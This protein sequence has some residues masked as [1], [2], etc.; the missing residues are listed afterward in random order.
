[1]TS[2][3]RTAYPRFK[4]LITAH[5]LQ[6]L[7]EDA[8]P[9]ATADGAGYATHVL[10]AA[11]HIDLVE[12]LLA[13]GRSPHAIRRAQA[14]LVRAVMDDTRRRWLGDVVSDLMQTPAGAMYFAKRIS[15]CGS[16]T[17]SAAAMN[18]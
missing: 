18:W 6:N 10:L 16:T 9:G 4:R 8:A 11:L 3:E 14:A 5:E 13:T 17:T 12:E 1:M 15:A 7:I 2:I